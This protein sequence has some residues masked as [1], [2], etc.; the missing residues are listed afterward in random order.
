MELQSFLRHMRD[1]IM[2]LAVGDEHHDD[3]AVCPPLLDTSG[4]HV[5]SSSVPGSAIWA[6]LLQ[7]G[8]EI[9]SYL[10][11]AHDL[12]CCMAQGGR[13]PASQRDTVKEQLPSPPHA[14]AFERR[15][16]S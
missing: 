12:P 9:K 11:V 15:E 1:I 16:L 10:L 13:L 7:L 3:L 2:R 14:P 6:N 8:N 5:P 4:H